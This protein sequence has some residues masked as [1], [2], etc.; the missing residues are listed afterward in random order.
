MNLLTLDF[1][2]YFDSDYTL[3]KMTTEDYIRNPRFEALCL[4]IRQVRA[5]GETECV[6]TDEPRELLDEFDWPQTAV[7]A[8]HAHF[9]GLIL[10]HHYGVKPAFWFDTLSMARL[11]IGNH[12]SVSLSNLSKHF[13][14]AAKSVPYDLFKGRHWHEL[15]AAEQQAVGDGC[16]HDVELTYQLFEL[17]KPQVPRDEFDLIDLTVRMFTEPSIVGDVPMLRG[18][19]EREHERKQTAMAALGVTAKELASAQQFAAILTGLGV[20]VETKLSPAGNE[21]P[22][23]AKTDQFM[24]DLV[25]D[26]NEIVA[27]LAQARL[28]ARS[29]I[30][31][32][33]AGRLAASASRGRVP[34]YLSYCAAHTTR[35]GGGDRVNFQNFRRG[36]DV[37][38]SLMAPDGHLLL[39]VD[40]SQI[41]CRLLEYV[42]GET[43]AIEE[44][45]RGVDPYCSIASKFHG[46]EITKADKAE[47]GMGKQIRLSCGYGAGGPSIVATAKRGTYGPPVILT[48][49][50]GLAARDLYRRERPEVV[51]LWREGDTVLGLIAR[52]AA[53]AGPEGIDWRDVVSIEPGAIVLPNG[54]RMLYTLEWDAAE[55]GWKRK[56]R[57]GWSRIWGGHLVENLIQGLARVYIGEVMVKVRHELPSLRLAWMSHDEL[58]YVV[59][60][61]EGPEALEWVLA[62]M[63]VAPAWAPDIPLDA[64]GS[65]SKRYEK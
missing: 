17:L 57:K 65:L 4:G 20:E 32:T 41:E 9:D 28:D 52:G 54:T 21:I 14:L 45:R 53:S 61:V 62:R 31:E 22:A 39:V 49:A 37:R 16:A 19:A 58:V 1:E 10:S 60:Q 6:W 29:T 7:L 40:A 12:L 51:K 24:K 27:G 34:I 56:T 3:K 18:I 35:W 25:E 13:G 30:D 50:Q 46:R 33:R 55:R 26:E 8:H 23:V 36:G 43:E 11:L 59:R 47:R 38:K 44:F 63:R 42:A 5:D 2:T 48:D 15:S 64:E